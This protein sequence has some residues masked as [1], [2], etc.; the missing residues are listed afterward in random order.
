MTD[1]YRSIKTYPIDFKVPLSDSNR[2]YKIFQLSNGI[3][4]LLISDPGNEIGSASLCVATGSHND[5]DYIPGL[6]HL[7]EHTL[8][9]GTKEFPKSYS[10]HEIVLTYGGQTNAFTT[11]EK[12]CFH[13]EVPVING[14][15]GSIN[16]TAN[17]VENS[18]ESVFDY[19]LRN[20]ASFFKCP[21][22]RDRD[23]SNEILSVNDEFICNQD[24]PEKIFFN[25]L[26]FLSN[27]NHPF[28]RFATGNIQTLESSPKSLKLN[29]SSELFKFF[30]LYYIPENMTLVISG[31][32]SLNHLQRLALMNFSSISKKSNKNKNYSENGMLKQHLSEFSILS[33]SWKKIYLEPVFKQC[34]LNKCL[35]I[36][37]KNYSRLR[38]IFH[39][40]QTKFQKEYELYQSAWINILGDESLGSLCAYLIGSEDLA[41]SLYLFR[42]SLTFQDD[43]LILDLTLTSK[44]KN[45]IQKILLSVFQYI[46]QIILKCSY[47]IMGKYLSDMASIETL[48]FIYRE[49]NYCPME[50]TAALAEILQ[51]DLSVITPENIL[52]GCNDWID[53]ELDYNGEYKVDPG[54]WRL[55]AAKFIA[56][57]MK[58]LN[59]ENCNILILDSNPL[60]MR[61]IINHSNTYCR[62]PKYQFHDVEYT[63]RDLDFS[64]I[65]KKSSDYCSHFSF[66]KPNIYFVYKQKDLNSI[67]ENI[68]LNTSNMSW[69]FQAYRVSETEPKLIDSSQFH[70]VWHMY[71][72]ST[73]RIMASCRLQSVCLESSPIVTIGIEMLIEVIGNKMRHELYPGELVGYYWGLFPGMNC[74]PA[75]TVTISGFEEKLSM[76]LFVIVEKIREVASNIRDLSYKDLKK[77]RDSVRRHY[78]SLLKSEGVQKAIAGSVVLLEEGIWS[79]KDRLDALDEIDILVLENISLKLFDNMHHICIFIQGNIGMDESLRVSRMLQS[80]GICKSNYNANKFQITRPSSYLMQKGKSYVYEDKDVLNGATNTIFYY[81]QIGSREDAFTRTIAKFSAHILSIFAATELRTKRKL[82][83]LVYSGCKLF[84]TTTG[85]F[86]TISSGSYDPHYLNSQIEN[87]LYDLELLL[88]RYSEENF[89]VNFKQTFSKIYSKQN[90]QKEKSTLGTKLYDVNPVKSSSVFPKGKMYHMHINYFD[91]IVN[92]SYYFG[93]MNGDNEVDILIVDKL[94]KNEFL[95]FFRSQISIKSEKKSSLSLQLFS[96]KRAKS[97]SLKSQILEILTE[98][99]ISVSS[100]DFED[101]LG[102]CKKNFKLSKGVSDVDSKITYERTKLTLNN[103]KKVYRVKLEKFKSSKKGSNIM[104]GLGDNYNSNVPYLV[105]II[106]ED[107]K[108]LHKE[109]KLQR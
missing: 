98:E 34:N 9:M 50:E 78:E 90:I 46:N 99:G 52:K 89:D 16:P 71:E 51:K 87:F 11:G 29:L 40:K 60:L 79:L 35:F 69:G 104:K 17:D 105:P 103:L 93:G 76:F 27:K 48:N 95:K 55:M 58:I 24:S 5:P 3:L 61:N 86:I 106:L 75:I 67:V 42:Q 56:A 85:I 59:T 4:T 91:K 14:N 97:K 77:S 36:K 84:R 2:G 83:Y 13:F 108:Q 82:G 25:S 49:S 41:I 7:C 19:V 32:Q 64:S 12:T 23:I 62:N 10:Y 8:M 45:N 15:T 72:K 92:K 100:N 54:W 39:M 44:G 1:Y 33:Q 107:C 37:S 109:C 21:L 30:Q 22:F 68:S 20:F 38:I 73:P 53:E 66:P 65:N 28:S 102:K 88:I 57:T 6:A 26:K 81:I 47:E 43:A 31:P 74:L 18:S 101:L 63:I 70:E 80:L 96:Q 94:T